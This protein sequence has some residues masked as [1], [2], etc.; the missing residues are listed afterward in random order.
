MLSELNTLS[1]AAAW[2]S[3][4]SGKT[5]S[6]KNVIEGFLKLNPETVYVVIESD[7]PLARTEDGE[8]KDIS[9]PY[10]IGL[11]ACNVRTFLEVMLLGFSQKTASSIPIN[12]VNGGI[13]MARVDY[14]ALSPIYATAIRLTKEDILS[15]CPFCALVDDLNNGEHPTL[16]AL[17][18]D[19]G[20]KREDTEKTGKMERKKTESTKFKEELAKI[21][22]AWPKEKKPDAET[23]V[24]RAIRNGLADEFNV[25]EGRIYFRSGKSV[26]L[27]TVQ[28][29]L[30]WWVKLIYLT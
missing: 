7:T 16:H 17:L 2:L 21:Y 23:L 8:W 18:D 12:L 27:K 19:I 28:N 3:E 4:N 20:Q 14:R 6:W 5:W 13:G 25:E 22:H 24:N 11:Y 26:V 30:W 10:P 29:W 1:E 9:F 15:I